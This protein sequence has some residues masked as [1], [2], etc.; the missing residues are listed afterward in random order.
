MARPA[1]SRTRSVKAWSST[2]API[3]RGARKS[4]S[5]PSTGSRPVGSLRSGSDSDRVA[6]GRVSS[7]PSH[8]PAPAVR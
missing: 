6:A 2:V 3:G 5:V 8:G 4:N 7:Q 1:S